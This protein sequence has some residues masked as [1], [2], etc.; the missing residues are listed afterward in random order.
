M[1]KMYIQRQIDTILSDWKNE[2][3]RKPLLLRG[4]RQVGKSST[5]R[6]LGQ[7]FEYFVEINF[8]ARPSFKAVFEQDLSP[9][10]ICSQLSLL[11]NTPII[12][13]KTLLFFDEIQ[14]CIP[15]IS[16]LRFFYEQKPAL[17][18]V[19]AGSLLE[20]ALHQIP[21]F[22]VGRIRSVFL[23]PFL[24]EEFL[25]AH[26]EHLLANALTTASPQKPLPAVIHQKLLGYFKKFL[27]VGGMPEAVSS[28]VN[29]G[30]FLKVQR[31]LNDLI[32]SIQADFSKYKQRVP[33]ARI[34]E[35][36]NAIV[37]QMGSQF[38]YTF[39]HTTLSIAQVKEAVELLIL[40]GLVI[41]VTHSAS[42]GLPLGAEINPKKR[43]LLLFDT[44][45]YQ[46]FLNLDISQIIIE[47]DF[48]SVNK[49]AIAELHVGLELLKSVSNYERIDLH[50]WHREAKSSQAE[51]DY[52]IQLQNDIVPIEVKASK[53]GSMQSLFV[54]MSEKNLKRGLRMS[55]E[56]FGQ[57]QQV[58]V[59]PLYA[60]KNIRQ[61]TS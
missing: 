42:N 20:F 40:A 35:V 12:D 41:P 44:G 5:V 56:N 33:T 27:V 39:A 15:A 2:S 59:F 28:Y 23:Y 31:I 38:T 29:D 1:N 57:Y 53:Q 22:G 25:V 21:S 49:G 37:Q 11:T 18:L 52:V 54:F 48:N 9:N 4:A 47:N 10:E 17:H 14:A 26:Q 58:H 61:I 36:F 46:R 24:F 19:A 6:Q 55:L 32:I 43:K 30:D 16:S 34:A 3:P 60:V 51:I 50:Y 7:Q 13:G 8:E 45:I